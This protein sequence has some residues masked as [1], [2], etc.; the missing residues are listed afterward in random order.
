VA[1]GLAAWL[2]VRLAAAVVIAVSLA[3]PAA[4]AQEVAEAP[5]VFP[6]GA[7]RDEVFYYCTGCHSSRLV[8]NQ[9]MTRQ[10][11]DETLSWMTERHNMAPLEGEDR[12]RFLDYLT[13]AFGPADGAP[14]PR[15]PFLTAP[16]RKNPFAQP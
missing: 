10:Q 3:G 4:V 7:H 13:Q 6:D 12:A 16:Q 5:T 11:W 2:A 1:A 15:A 9:R 14:P 8:R